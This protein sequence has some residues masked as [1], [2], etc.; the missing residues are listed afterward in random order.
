MEEQLRVEAGQDPRG[1]D[2][3]KISIGDHAVGL[4]VTTL[5]KLIESLGAI[6]A[7]LQPPIPWDVPNLGHRIEALED[8]NWHLQA[9]TEG[10]VI[11]LTVLHTGFGPLHFAFPKK[12]YSRLQETLDDNIV[13]AEAIA[14]QDPPH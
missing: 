13:L 8:P 9:A 10:G 7:R 1:N 2:A 3:V 14:P 5:S 6:R 4:D 12:S 11:L